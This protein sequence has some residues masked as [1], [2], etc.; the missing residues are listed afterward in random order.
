MRRLREQDS[1]DQARQ[2]PA[3]D[4]QGIDRRRF[5]ATASAVAAGSA[6]I[7]KAGTTTFIKTFQ[8]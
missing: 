1:I 5:L 6:M 4:G 2:V 8:P 7:P 3:R